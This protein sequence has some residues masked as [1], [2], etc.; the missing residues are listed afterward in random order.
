MEIV[1]P[2]RDHGPSTFRYTWDE[3]GEVQQVTRVL[4]DSPPHQQQ[5]QQRPYRGRQ[6]V[7]W[8]FQSIA[9][10]TELSSETAT[11]AYNHRPVTWQPKRTLDSDTN[12]IE[13]D[14]VPDYVKNYIRG[15]TPETVAR[16]K[17]NGGKLG[18]RGVDV[19]HQHRPH[20]S[21]VADFEGF[22]D[23]DGVQA[24]SRI[25]SS[26]DGDEER[27]ILSSGAREKGGQTKGWRGFMVGWRAGVVLNA[28]IALIILIAGFVLLVY[29][30]SR[31]ASGAEGKAVVFR[32]ACGTAEG[33]HWGL[34]AGINVF[35]VVLVAGANYVFQVLSSPTRTEVAVAHFRRRWVDVGIPS[36]R[37]L[38]YVE[39]GRAWLA[40]GVVLVAGVTQVIYNS[41]VFTTQTVADYKLVLAT[42]SFLTGAPFSNDT[43]SNGG[44]L[45]RIDIASLQQLANRGELRNL[46]AGECAQE[47]G[48]VFSERFSAALLISD[49]NSQTSSV[50]QT[51]LGSLSGG[52]SIA[53]L[54]SDLGSIKYCLAQPAR[55]QT[56]EVI[57]SAPLLG[58][59]ALLNVITIVCITAVL[60]RKQFE[61]LATLGDAISSFLKEPDMNTR[62]CCLLSKTD[63][64]QG[65]WGLDAAKYYVPRDHYWFQSAS[66]PRWLIAL[67]IWVCCAGCAAAALTLSLLSEPG[68]RLS[69][70][71]SASPY[72]ILPFA[73]QDTALALLTS[74]PHILLLALYLITNS[75][76]TTYHLSHESSLFAIGP[77]RP[78]RVSSNPEGTQT[79]SL[80]LTLPRPT[81]WT[82]L[83]VFVG[84]AFTLSQ[85]IF[86]V[87]LTLSD[88]PISDSAASAQGKPLR[89][90][91][92][93]STALL[94]FL[95]T[96]TLLAIAV[97][98]LGFR[99]AP[100]AALVNGQAVGNPMTL[101]AGSC[102]A[103]ISARCHV[104]AEAS[105]RGLWKRN[106]VW[107]TVREGV[108]M[109]VSHCGFSGGSVSV[110]DVSRSYA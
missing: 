36:W 82:L 9:T 95:S 17:R 61:P 87:S 72:T 1:I 22:L 33:I 18:E 43:A 55:T 77:P 62:G 51:A 85:S 48:G 3:N 21:R 94:I 44:L 6:T 8:P 68:T 32:G 79:T 65:R 71:G 84:M 42:D 92:F 47:F 50:V 76:L 59:V 103:V 91:G 13:Q 45:S 34:K 19:A 109:D 29:S 101:P 40:V 46:T 83:I 88:T 52:G 14:L 30:L 104:G 23:L 2:P 60:L 12:S 96:L 11:S 35:C 66:L 99:R 57:A 97:I 25:G 64:W 53:N 89:A 41:A 58:A 98:A 93:S 49:V 86:P 27:G 69:P 70:F 54:T 105:E 5:P 73:V 16:R 90:L 38:G 80:Y 37:N 10:E 110:V 74:L 107:G 15:E 78:L 7:Q 4:D 81:S 31:G 26:D 106:V 56:C 63:V 24:P 100:A 20:Q 67:F 108:G 39:G 28:L 75:I 102:S